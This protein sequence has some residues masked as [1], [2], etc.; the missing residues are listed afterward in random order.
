MKTKP[1]RKKMSSAFLTTTRSVSQSMSDKM[2][3]HLN[4][5]ES[6]VEVE[7]SC[8]G[9]SLGLS[10]QR[11]KYKYGIASVAALM[12]DELRPI[13]ETLRVQRASDCA[14]PPGLPLCSRPFVKIDAS[15]KG[16]LLLGLICFPIATACHLRWSSRQPRRI[17]AF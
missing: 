1:A 12:F 8:L 3:M 6:V 11:F 15:C 4:Q 7:H 13:N 16:G 5:P 10:V 14:H 2:R 17:H 9:K